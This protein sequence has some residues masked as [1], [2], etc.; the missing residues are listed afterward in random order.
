[1]NGDW[2]MMVVG[3]KGLP[4]A[5]STFLYKI[6]IK[7]IKKKYFLLIMGFGEIDLHY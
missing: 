3:K 6:A 4:F 1:M 2:Q 7:F 5:S